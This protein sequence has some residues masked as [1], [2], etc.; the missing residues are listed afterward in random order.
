[1]DMHTII[2]LKKKGTSNRDVAR[3]TGFDRKT[4]ARYWA[5]Y[6]DSLIGIEGA[7]DVRAAQDEAVSPPRYDASG[8]SPR[9]YTEEMDRALDKILVAEEQKRERLGAGNKQMRTCA[10]IHRELVSQGFDIGQTTITKRVAQKR[11]ASREA[12]IAQHYDYGQRLEYDFGEVRLEIGGTVGTYYLAVLASP[13]SKF[14]WAYLYRNQKK[15][16]FLDSHVRFFE[17]TGGAWGEVV[18]D[19]MRNVVTRFIGRNERELNADLVKMSLYYGFDVNVTS[20]FAGNEKG[21][22]ESSV[23]ALRREVFATEYRFAT[24]EDAGIYLEAT[25]V[26]LAVAS[27]IEEEKPH[28]QAYRPPL[29]VAR[30][31]ENTVDKYSFVRIGNNFYSVPDYLVGR[32][33]TVK[34]YPSEIVVYSGLEKVCEHKRR[35][36]PGAMS[37]DIFHY[38][39]TLARKPGALSRS[40]ALRQSSALKAVFDEGFT[41]R[42]R[43]FIECLRENKGRPLDEVVC[44]CKARAADTTSFT[45][46][47]EHGIA[48]NVLAHS[49]RQL[50]AISDAFLRRGERVAS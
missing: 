28:L 24:L 29:E 19:N 47:P 39:D 34:A 4:V 33:V 38:L 44:A 36:G 2:T 12:F 17:M 37:V 50:G 6:Q 40:A 13:A 31:T 5:H 46:S 22:V 26:A 10:Q 49:R 41:G 25:L 30:V 14:R 9:K 32:K 23:K 27:T 20:C 18:Y 45:S 7:Q 42:A 21:F 16:V 15:D 35:V 8:R 3:Q 11:R 1:M 43:E 48:S